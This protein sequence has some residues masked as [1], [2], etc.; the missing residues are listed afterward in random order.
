MEEKDKNNKDTEKQ[1]ISGNITRRIKID[2]LKFS[3][4]TAVLIIA[5][6][7]FYYYIIFLP[8]Q[9]QKEILL[10]YKVKFQKE[11]EDNYYKLNEEYLK[12]VKEDRLLTFKV[13]EIHCNGVDYEFSPEEYFH[14]LHGKPFVHTIKSY[15]S[16]CI[17]YKIKQIYSN[18]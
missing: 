6:S 11:C 2:F 15:V 10:N 9:Q 18:F 16:M 4:I 12:D 8:K 14:C 3:I 13:M 7:V 5:L 1:I 17:D